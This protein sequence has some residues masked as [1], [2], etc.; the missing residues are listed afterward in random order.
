[1]ALT[2]TNFGLQ[3]DTWWRYTRAYVWGRRAGVDLNLETNSL[4]SSRVVLICPVLQAFA[5]DVRQVWM[6]SSQTDPSRQRLILRLSGALLS[7][8]LTTQ[9]FPY[10]YTALFDRL[11]TSW[12]LS[13]SR[14]PNPDTYD[15]MCPACS[16]SSVLP[17][18][19]ACV[20]TM[21]G[22]KYHPSCA[23]GLN[24]HPPAFLCPLCS[25]PRTATR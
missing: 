20:C 19:G 25:R 16:R 2:N 12:V 4:S 7:S 18:V 11:L 8:A 22:G 9:P 21:C 13:A 6:A 5:R 17:Q 14:P 10:V 1:V 3:H 15:V 24:M 23:E